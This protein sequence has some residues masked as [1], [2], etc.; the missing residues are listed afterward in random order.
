M[1]M[2]P[3][4]MIVRMPRVGHDVG[5]L[6]FFVVTPFYA[7]RLPTPWVVSQHLR[8]FMQLS[9]NLAMFIR[10]SAA[11]NTS[12]SSYPIQVCKVCHYSFDINV[13]NRCCSIS[14]SNWPVRNAKNVCPSQLRLG[15]IFSSSRLL[16]IHSLNKYS[17]ARY[18]GI[19]NTKYMPA[20]ST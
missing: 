13:C 11:K 6:A 4:Y 9:Y 20:L 15:F 8:W 1:Y 2:N 19:V 7:A 12:L 10:V 18:T 14:S 16:H 5:F 17:I 3:L